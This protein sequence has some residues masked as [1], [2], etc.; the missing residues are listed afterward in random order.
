MKNIL[1]PTDFSDNCNKAAKLAIEMAVLFN[2]EIHFLHQISTVVNWT[3]L[4]KTQEQNYPD[5]LAEIGIANSN[6]RALEIEAEHKGL[7]SRTFLKFVSGT[8]AT[9]EHSHDFHHDFILTGSKGMQNG[10][11]KKLLGNNAQKIIR[12]ANV[13]ILVVKED[14]ITFP[15][16]NIVFVSDFKE[17]ISNAF[18]E[19]EKIAKKC[20]AKIHL[21]N[22]NTT[23]DFN[24]IENGLHPIRMFLKHFP[25]L[26]NYAMHVYNESTVLGGIEKFESSNDVDLIVMYTHS[27]K[28]LSSIFSKSIAENITNHSKQPVLTVHL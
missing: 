21:L 6:L 17:D 25:K 20:N 10:F 15:F 8:D 12:K 2:A 18:K 14:T 27:R 28:G 19:V 7:R 24:S 23:S 9:L 16:E 22:I 26:E 4:S 13:P 11:L 3:K 1:V 5:T